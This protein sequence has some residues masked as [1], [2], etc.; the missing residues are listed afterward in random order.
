MTKYEK[1]VEEKVLTFKTL[2]MSD[3]EEVSKLM[4]DNLKI[5]PEMGDEEKFRLPS[6]VNSIMIPSLQSEWSFVIFSLFRVSAATIN[7]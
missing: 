5:N 7:C 2:T 6:I 4:M 1:I 3:S